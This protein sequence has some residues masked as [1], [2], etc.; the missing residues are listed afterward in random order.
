M[1]GEAMNSFIKKVKTQSEKDELLRHARVEWQEA[2]QMSFLI[3][4]TEE[5]FLSAV[6][7]GIEV[8]GSQSQFVP[9]EPL[10]P[11]RSGEFG[12]EIEVEAMLER[13]FGP[14]E[15]IPGWYAK[16]HAED[17]RQLRDEFLAS[18]RRAESAIDALVEKAIKRVFQKV[19]GNLESSTRVPLGVRPIPECQGIMP[20]VR[21]AAEYNPS[22]DAARFLT[23][24]VA[25]DEAGMRRVVR[26]IVRTEAAA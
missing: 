18:A 20:L 19:D 25:G 2:G 15:E 5:D 26:E 12:R 16:T 24:Y 14:K 7:D 10:S 6:A 22:S 8:E 4:P 13:V 9:P 23:A 17:Q 1:K 21:A 3:A 11:E